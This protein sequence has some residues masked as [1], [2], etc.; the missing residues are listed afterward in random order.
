MAEGLLLVR[1]WIR[2]KD[3]KKNK[4]KKT[5]LLMKYVKARPDSPSLQSQ[6]LKDGTGGLE[7]QGYRVQTHP[8]QISKTAK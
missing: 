4:E 8:G 3:E 7:V 1:P 2:P 5:K 6:L